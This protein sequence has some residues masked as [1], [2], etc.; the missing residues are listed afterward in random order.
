MLAVL[1]ELATGGPGEEELAHDIEDLVRQLRD[2][3][4]AAGFLGGAAATELVTGTPEPIATLVPGRESVTSAGAAAALA[5]ALP[6]LLLLLPPG[7]RAGADRS[8]FTEY[9]YDSPRRVHGR[10]FRPRGLSI[11]E[12]RRRELVIGDEGITFSDGAGVSTVLWDELV[13]ALGWVDDTRGVWSADGYYVEVN[14]QHWRRG[15]AAVA[16]VER[17]IPPELLVP[18]DTEL[19][20][21]IDAV[22]VAIEGKL[23]RGWMTGQELDNLPHVLERGEQLEVV[24]AA[25]RGIRAGLL[26]VTDRR[27]L[28]L[29]LDEVELDVGRADVRDARSDAG[30]WLSDNRLVV[31]TAQGE[32]TF[33]D[34]KP[35]ERVDEFLALLRP[36]RD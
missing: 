28:F 13:G 31:E 30:G 25:S 36:Q 27:V 32:Q 2:P 6:S 14:P 23:K 20:E 18:M 12:A 17:R 8:R 10:R 29:Y 11:G 7:T 24:A 5:D 16:E 15:R 33:T 34:I 21:R 1:D 19:R 3:A 4:S 26:A 22:G 9:P 35:D